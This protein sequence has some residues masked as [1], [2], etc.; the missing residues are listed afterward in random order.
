[1]ES[2]PSPFAKGAHEP[3]GYANGSDRGILRRTPPSA[4]SHQSSSTSFYTPWAA[5][6]TPLVLDPARVTPTR[7][8]NFSTPAY[9]HHRTPSQLQQQRA[10]PSQQLLLSLEKQSND[11]AAAFARTSPKAGFLYKLGTNIPEFK[12][13]FFVLKP[14]THLYYFLSPTDTE[15]RGCIEL[16]GSK[17]EHLETLPDG[18]MRFAIRLDKG[19]SV[20]LE[21]R[22]NGPEWIA[23]LQN[24]RLSYCQQ[25]LMQSRQLSVG[26]KQRISDLEKQVRDYQMVEKD[27]DGALED[28]ANW[29]NRYEQLNEA[30]RLLTNKLMKPLGDEGD[31]DYAT[32]AMPNEFEALETTDAQ[33][34]ALHN[35]CQ[36]LCESVRL[37]ST[38]ASTAVEDLLA[39][40][41]DKSMIEKRLQKAEKHL[42]K[43][44][45]ENTSMRQELKVVRKEKRILVKEVKTLRAKTADRGF[46]QDRPVDEMLELSSSAND[47][48]GERLID[49]LEAQV[50][51]SIRLQEQLLSANK[52][53]IMQSSPDLNISD[54][55]ETA[56]IDNSVNGAGLQEDEKHRDSRVSPIEPKI[57]SLMDDDSSDEEEDDDGIG[58]SMTC[59]VSTAGAE[60]GD[61]S[62]SLGT[63]DKGDKASFS[64]IDSDIES[65]TTERQNPLLALDENDSDS[66][67]EGS[68]QPKSVLTEN[69]QATSRL[70]CPLA[71][72]IET[73]D[74]NADK[75]DGKVYHLTFYSGKIG[76]QFQKV[77]PPSLANGVLTEAMV[78]DLGGRTNRENTA[79]ELN[80]IAAMAKQA[81]GHRNIDV[82]EQIECSVAMP[83]DAVLVCGF[84]GFDDTANHIR[85]ALGAR[86]VAFEGISVELGKWTFE[87][88]RKAIQARGRPLTLSFRNDFL[89]TQQR[90]ILTKAI[91][92][93]NA[94]QPQ[95]KP[96]IQYNISNAASLSKTSQQQVQS[97]GASGD[98]AHDSF[99][100]MESHDDEESVSTRS[101]SNYRHQTF[102][103]S[104]SVATGTQ[105][106]RSFSEAGTSSA[107]SQALRPLMGKLL[108]GV[109]KSDST[110]IPHYMKRDGESL[111]ALPS[112]RDF[113]SSLL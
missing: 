54:S 21:A 9:P 24:E 76:L 103:A 36:Q 30:M 107:F 37:A 99:G 95:P 51:S 65:V 57:L 13:R 77:P 43:L 98:T 26:Y 101:S 112:H 8:L 19:R 28:A 94:A 49:E 88:I 18:I 86:L 34:S 58:P 96:F 83:I 92:E 11:T 106:F 33:F 84:H 64:Y 46:L 109:V 27:R 68:D 85:P 78:S 15:P 80:R 32:K 108:S 40:K 91:A 63:A 56:K 61:A 35:V 72:V 2:S 100:R 75:E 110:G 105:D 81:R 10:P 4:E 82:H 53:E 3:M 1:M 22:S 45:E 60:F 5:P 7:S 87:S 47:S 41:D 48:E 38:E 73:S 52:I 62:S 50:E 44:W 111:E 20:I 113:Q 67:N 104:S 12:R 31:G 79:A 29:K 55:A 25:E 6:Q 23:S 71:D 14:S 97:R 102:S 39:I 69:G 89:T 70:E 16:E 66:V 42:C 17:V 93:V 59:S 90:A 74:N